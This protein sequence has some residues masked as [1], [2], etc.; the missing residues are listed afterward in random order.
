MANTL[1]GKLMEDKLKN[2]WTVY[3]FAEYFGITPEEFIILLERTFRQKAFSR[4]RKRLNKN[5]KNRN[6]YIACIRKRKKLDVQAIVQ[7][8]TILDTIN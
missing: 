4:M 7:I 8:D 3:E 5:L 2:G 1:N 6:K